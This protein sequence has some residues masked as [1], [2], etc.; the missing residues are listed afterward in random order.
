MVSGIVDSHRGFGFPMSRQ[1][2]V[3]N[4]P[5]MGPWYDPNAPML[6]TPYTPEELATIPETERKKRNPR[7][8]SAKPN[9]WLGKPKGIKQV[10]WERGLWKEGTVRKMSAKEKLKCMMENRE[11]APRHGYGLHS[12]QLF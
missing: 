9:G 8:S 12:E 7:D 5:L 6:D 10:L 1:S 11:K 3:F 2:V 4:N